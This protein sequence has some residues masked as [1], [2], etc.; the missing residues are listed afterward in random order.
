[1]SALDWVVLLGT[2]GVITGYGLWKTRG[3]TDMSAY[4]HGGYRDHWLTVGFAVMA[5]QASAIT[6]LSVPGQ[7]Y[8][9]GLRFIQFYFGLP[10]AMV[11]LSIVFVP[12][13]YRLR[14]LTAYEVLE[15]RFDLKTRQ[16]TAFLFLLQRGLSAGITIY[17]P[18][19]VLSKV[20]GWSLNL[21]N[22][23]IGALVIFYTVLGG[24][25][26]VNQTQRHQMIVMLGGMVVA[27]VIVVR[28][29]PADL[30]FDHALAVAGTFGKMNAVDFG[31]GLSSRY[32]VWSGLL[33][34]GFLAMAY[35]GTDQSQVQRYLSG[36]SVTESR[37]GLLFNALLKIPMQ[38]LILFVGVMVFVYYQFNAP[39]LFFNEAELA[40]VAKTPQASALASLEV[41]HRAAFAHKRQ[42][43][44]ALVTALR[45]DA[46]GAANAA[47]VSAARARVVQAAARSNDIRARTRAL[48]ER[49]VPRPE[50]K[51]GD[52]VFISFVIAN[53]PR[54][55]I[56]LLIAVI[57]CA[58]M[59]STASELSAL[60]SCTVVDFYR[61]SFRPNAP[62]AHYLRV[63]K[64]ATFGWGILAVVFAASAS[65][66][67]NLIQ[68]VNILGSLFYG[69]ILGIFLAAFLAP[70]LRATPVFIAALISETLVIGLWL[71]TDIGFLWFNVIGCAAVLLL[72]A[73]L[74]LAVQEPVAT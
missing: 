48:I 30:S 19:I 46:A 72:A 67:D 16:L 50:T 5:T 36:R 53:F 74:N 23:A 65:L 55:L 69:T 54:G 31:G 25:R 59:S 41:E 73:A 44:E 70:R 35:F 51:D 49:A 15:K 34:G 4:L 1:M 43:V 11:V 63:A 17:A 47:A 33:G 14:A 68:A 26:A 42:E 45:S 3:A 29:L 6:F 18:A 10:L 40:R 8:E 2:L 57:L 61:R 37:L 62:D 12:R 71:A 9:D 38:L 7:A 52:Y 13:F 64:A 20:F 28:R 66:L 21:T 22:L 32:T 56:G 60:G 27:F 24:T 39:P 58:A